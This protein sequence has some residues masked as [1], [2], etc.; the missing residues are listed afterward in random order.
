MI[1][2][3][4][5]LSISGTGSEKLRQRR[6]RAKNQSRL[7]QV[8][9]LRQVMSQWQATISTWDW[10]TML[11]VVKGRNEA[12]QSNNLVTSFFLDLLNTG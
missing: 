2:I 6:M 11:V 4:G 10:D 5:H 3:D 1:E 9:A 8:D 12:S 7:C